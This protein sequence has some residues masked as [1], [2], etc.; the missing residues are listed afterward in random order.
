MTEH[1][2]NPEPVELDPGM[3]L[4]PKDVE[5]LNRLYAEDEVPSYHPILMIW[6]EVLKPA[7]EEAKK[8]VT[9]QW[10]SRITSA[11]REVN[12]AD[13]DYVRDS[14]YGK[15]AE[16][17]RILDLEI[18][19]DEECLTYTTPEEDVEENGYHYKNLL[20]QWQLAFLQ[21]EMAWS[22]TDEHAGPELAA[23][24]EAHKMFFGDQG[25]TAFLENIQF[26]FT[27]DDQQTLADALIEFRGE[28]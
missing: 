26:P 23:I 6:R 2:E 10:A 19:T 17:A 21:W 12:Y 4:N 16:L 22:C 28:G 27:E 25:I 13:M 14:Y 18:E 20:L 15:I 3:I 8:K 1:T 9:P 11:Y 7:V 5:D 24:S